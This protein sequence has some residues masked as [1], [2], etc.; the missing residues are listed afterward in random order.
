MFTRIVNLSSFV[1][2]VLADK[3]PEVRDGNIVHDGVITER[4][5]FDGG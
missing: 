4:F 5:G 2:A 3:L 1:S